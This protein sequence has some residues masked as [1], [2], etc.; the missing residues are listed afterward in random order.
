MSVLFRASSVGIG[1]NICTSVR[2]C[3][4]SQQLR[5]AGHNKWSKIKRSKGAKDANRAK[6]FSKATR[7]IRVAS[8]IC[9]GDM[10][11]LHLQSAVQAAKAL[12]VPKDRIKDAINCTSKD[13]GEDLVTMRYDG[14]IN[15]PSGRVLV[16]CTALTDNKNRTAANV[17]SS[18][19]KA[20][21]ELASSGANDWLFDHVGV[22]LVHKKKGYQETEDASDS[23]STERITINEEDEDELLE[24]ALEN[25]ALDVDFGDGDDDMHAFVTC[26]T[27]DLYPLVS[28]LRENNYSV[29][30]FENR[31]ILKD[32]T[33][34]IDLDEESTEKFQK[35]L[36]KMD[37]DE[38]VNSVFY[39]S[40]LFE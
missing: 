18:F 1:L 9:G 26:E 11:N 20:D 38:D 28:A 37:E 29:S 31:Y 32:E 10:T 39:N 2:S 34:S 40:K 24:C 30:E 14:H 36:D 16:I 22:A 35:F 23:L 15:T 13:T 6:I 3:V 27:S 17:R 12:Q 8:K 5:F 7:A 33:S 25:G 4:Q 21:G 19:R